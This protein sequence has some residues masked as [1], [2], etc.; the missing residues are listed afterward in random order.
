MGEIFS[1]FCISQFMSLDVFRVGVR[2]Y[3]FRTTNFQEN[4]LL[5][6]GINQTFSVYSKS[7]IYIYYPTSKQFGD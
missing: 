4:V 2:V 3:I 5:S 1:A 7:N 6:Y